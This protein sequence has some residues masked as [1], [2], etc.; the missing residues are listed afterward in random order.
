MCYQTATVLPRALHSV[1]VITRSK[2][3]GDTLIHLLPL[4]AEIQS[5]RIFYSQKR[6]IC[7]GVRYDKKAK[8]EG[9]LMYPDAKALNIF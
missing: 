9:T 6:C 7:C 5:R 1:K 2:T 3:L 8:V 4:L